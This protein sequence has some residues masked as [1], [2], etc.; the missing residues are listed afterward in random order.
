MFRFALLVS[1]VGFLSLPGRGLTGGGGPPQPESPARSSTGCC[2]TE[3][4]GKEGM[5]SQTSP[6]RQDLS[7]HQEPKP[8]PA[9]DTAGGMPVGKALA[10]RRSVRTFEDR[11]ISLRDL[12]QLSW[13]GQGIT[14]P[15]SA[16]R[17][18][19]R[20][21]PS[22]GALYPLELYVVAG[23]VEGL[24]PGVY[25]YEPALHRLR[26]VA[27]GDRRAALARA[28]LN[29]AAVSSAPAVFVV[30]AVVGRTTP[31]YGERA[32][33]YVHME[34]GAAVENILLQAVA[35][36]LGGVFVGAFQDAQVGQALGIL[37]PEEVLALVPVGP[38]RTSPGA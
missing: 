11:A 5:M 23:K 36:G 14:Q 22:A 25:H 2:T 3:A 4:H 6:S 24:A 33:R 8:L 1:L 35:L 31:R 30:A 38:P 15:A 17:P 13:S 16:N 18:A 32:P 27:E 34:V 9:P 21:A 12:G 10:L 7:S 37:P 28:A 19:L 29:Q 20:T 26:P